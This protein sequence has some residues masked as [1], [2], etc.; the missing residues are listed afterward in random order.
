MGLDRIHLRVLREL[1]DVLTEPLPIT[2]QQ[3]WQNREVPPD[4]CLANV[5]PIH[6]KGRKDDPGNYRPVSLTSVPGKV[7]EQIIL[8]AIMCHIKDNQ[9]IRPSQCGFTKGPPCLTNLISFYDKVTHL[10]DEGKV[11]DVV[12]LDFS[13][14]FDIVSHSILL[15][16]LA[17]HGLNGSTLRWV[18]N[19]L[20]AGP[21]EWW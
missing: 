9:T 14:A 11:V 15:E 18:K 20:E 6:R 12:Y 17:A 13:K 5:G 19:W 2:Y 8:S 10:V 4:W 21:R 16:K 7:I 1:V 3:F